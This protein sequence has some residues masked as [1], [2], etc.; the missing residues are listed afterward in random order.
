L[1]Q[2]DCATSGD[3]EIGYA[4]PEVAVEMPGFWANRDGYG[5]FIRLRVSVSRIFKMETCLCSAFD[6]TF[7]L[8]TCC[9]LGRTSQIATKSDLITPNNR[10]LCSFRFGLLFAVIFFRMN[11]RICAESSAF[12]LAEGQDFG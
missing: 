12:L 4:M 10:D 2:K 6:K 11:G 1:T 7:L 8:D 3:K 5:L 9:N